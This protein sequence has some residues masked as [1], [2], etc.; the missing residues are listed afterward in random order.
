MKPFT[1][2]CGIIL[3]ALL[4]IQAVP[5][6][7]EAATLTKVSITFVTHDDNKDHDTR[8]NVAVKRKVSLFINK[9]IAR[10]DNVGGGM[11]FADPSRHTFDL[12]LNAG[13]TTI[14]DLKQ[15]VVAIDIQPNGTDR[16]FFSYTVTLTFDNGSS[17]TSKPQGVLLD[18]DNRHY[19]GLFIERP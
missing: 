3:S 11:E 6:R 19:E 18:Q 13:H 15:R 7:H 16:W 5:L 1:L 12:P 2:S 14:G 17:F 8:L 10:G 9:D 4:F